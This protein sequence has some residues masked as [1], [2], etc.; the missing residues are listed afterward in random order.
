M[1]AVFAVRWLPRSF[2]PALPVL[3]VQLAAV[4]AACA[5]VFYFNL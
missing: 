5:P 3:V 2:Q 4:I 1:I